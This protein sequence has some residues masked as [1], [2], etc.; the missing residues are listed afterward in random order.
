MNVV[1][2]GDPNADDLEVEYYDVH[3]IKGKKVSKS[4]PLL[5]THQ[6]KKRLEEG[7]V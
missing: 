7:I 1:F 3:V 2:L 4:V 5:V 6:Q